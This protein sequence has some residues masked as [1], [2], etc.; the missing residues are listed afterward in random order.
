MKLHAKATRRSG[1]GQLENRVIRIRVG[2]RSE[3]SGTRSA[4]G[5]GGHQLTVERHLD[6]AGAKDLELPLLAPATRPSVEQVVAMRPH[7]PVVVVDPVVQHV[8]VRAVEVEVRPRESALGR[9]D[10]APLRRGAARSGAPSVSPAATRPASER[11]VGRVG[12]TA[13]GIVLPSGWV[14]DARLPVRVLCRI[15]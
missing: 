9:P 8:Q 11:T 15:R 14:A 13:L 3:A 6:V 2:R 7:R 1:K 12:N 4:R 10:V 5:V